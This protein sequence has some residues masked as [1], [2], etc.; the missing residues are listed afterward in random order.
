MQWRAGWRS[1][2]EGPEARTGDE[3]SEYSRADGSPETLLH[4]LT[5]AAEV[6]AA[7]SRRPLA[8][9][10]P[11]DAGELNIER[12]ARR[13]FRAVCACLQQGSVVVFDKFR[14][15]EPAEALHDLLRGASITLSAT[16]P[17]ASPARTPASARPS[18]DESAQ[19]ESAA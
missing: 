4:S 8:L 19:P 17:T 13:D 7:R 3:G 14:D 1:Q 11:D 18:A 2:A 6:T 5:L 9:P 12:F 10:R 15:I 16:P